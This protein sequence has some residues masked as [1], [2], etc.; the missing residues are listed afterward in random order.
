VAIVWEI[1]RNVNQGKEAA[2]LNYQDVTLKHTIMPAIRL[3]NYSCTRFSTYFFLENLFKD[4]RSSPFY[5]IRGPLM[6][7]L[8]SVQENKIYQRTVY[9][10]QKFFQHVQQASDFSEMDVGFLQMILMLANFILSSLEVNLSVKESALSAAQEILDTNMRV[11]NVDLVRL[12]INM[13][14]SNYTSKNLSNYL[15]KLIRKLSTEELAIMLQRLFDYDP[16]ARQKFLMEILNQPEPLFCPVWFS[17]QM[18]IMQFD[19]EFFSL[20]RKIWNKYGLVL[21]QGVLDL[22]QEKQLSNLYCHLRSSNTGV[23]D[24]TVKAATA[25]IEIQAGRYDSIV[26]DLLRFYHS[27]IVI[28]KQLNLEALK[29]TGD[30]NNFEGDKRFNRIA[31]P[32]IVESTSKLIPHS[33][34]QKLLDF[35]IVTGSADSDPKVSKRCLEAADAIIHARGNDYA[36]KLL[37]ILEKFIENADDYAPESVNHAVVLIGTLSAYLDKNLQKKLIQTFEKMLQLLARGKDQG[38]SELVNKAICKCIPLLARFFEEKTQKTFTEQFSIIRMGKKESELRGAAYACAGIIKS[39]GMKFFGEKDVLGI[40]QK[41]CFMGKKTDPLRLQAGLQL[42]ETLSFS[43]GKAFEPFAKQILPNIMNC[44]SDPREQVRQC[45]NAANQQIIKNFSNY[46]IKQ[47]VPMFLE[48][49][50]NDNW[51]GKFAAVEAV[52]NMAYCAPK[53]ISGFLPDIV[54]ALREVLNDTHEK[55]HEAAINAVSKIGS[56]IKCPEVAELLDVIIK[57]L[58]NS[59]LYLNQCLDALLQTSFVHAIDAPSLSLLVPLVDV[60]LT[61]HDNSSKQMASQLM[62][63]ICNLTQDPEDLLPYMKILI[64]AIKN[65]LFDSIPEIRA[66]ASKALGKLSKGLGLANSIELL[67]WLNENLHRKDLAPSERSG[68]AQGL[69]EVVSSHGDNFF[70]NQCKE[71]ITLARS[72][73]ILLRESYRNVM[74][75]LPTS[76]PGFADYLLVMLPIMIEGLADESEEVRKVSMRNVKI[77]IQ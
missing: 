64:P 3:L 12:T 14:K 20:S 32:Q 57:A 41:E 37:Q 18:W 44:I 62:G 7:C 65:S 19:E 23:F 67:D 59:N 31:L 43:Q 24:M 52:G 48:G 71:I 68:A 76:F 6:S 13:M 27:E 36:G 1:L 69:S 10:F 5:G 58:G 21:R 61:M 45:A 60:G 29:N 55:V 72:K 30:D 49:L 15:N 47:V 38:A 11:K 70:S 40:L 63:N 26:D 4:N 28:V 56:V 35:F 16:I 2:I 39:Q 74:A 17:T 75:Y 54:T 73:E 22:A 33:S 25:A 8:Q 34:V 42:Y 46:A 9:D 53:Q 66:S 77:C 50:K 51:R